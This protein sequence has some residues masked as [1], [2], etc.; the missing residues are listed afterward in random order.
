M[1]DTYTQ[2]CKARK[3][4]Q[5]GYDNSYATRFNE[6]MVD[7][8]DA[9]IS[10]VVEIDI[11]SSTSVNLEALQNGTLSD[12]HFWR[13]QFTGTPASAVTVTVPASVT[14]SKRYLIDNQ[15]GQSLTFKYSATAGV[16]VPDDGK[17]EVYCDG[18]NTVRNVGIE[19]SGT[20][21]PAVRGS[22]TAGTYQIASNLCRYTRIGRRVW[23]DVLITM[24][25]VV[26]GGGT[27]ALAITG[28]PF[29]KI[30]NSY[31][32]GAARLSG[33]DWATGANLC[34]A[35]DNTAASSTLVYQ[36]TNDNAANSQI[37]IAGLAANDVIFG[38]ICYETDDA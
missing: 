2:S 8:L 22:G 25:P 37:G 5:N 38:S 11:G 20:W 6:D 12:S 29:A 15:T 13:L 33:V 17:V 1:A 18:T 23:L 4:E 26:T 21:T 34:I 24:A 36:E 30:A 7:I 32:V 28:I 9:A 14:P 31:P 27:S 35:F 10:G 3:I 16:T 19:Q